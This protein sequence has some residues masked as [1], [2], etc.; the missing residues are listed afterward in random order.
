[1]TKIQKHVLS[2]KEYFISKLEAD[3]RTDATTLQYIS[4]EIKTKLH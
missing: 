4:G 1:M 3:N 2:R